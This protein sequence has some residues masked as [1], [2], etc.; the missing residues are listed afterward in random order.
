MTCIHY[1]IICQRYRPKFCNQYDL[2]SDD[3]ED[4]DD[5][6][7]ET[8]YLCVTLLTVLE[9]ALEAGT[10]LT[11]MELCLPQPPECWD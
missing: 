7:S 5:L 9:L 4:D 2:L 3:E 6:F 11:L 8:G 10:G 1:L